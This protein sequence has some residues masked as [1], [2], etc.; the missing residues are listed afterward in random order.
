MRILRLAVAG[1]LLAPLAYLPATAQRLD[2][3]FAAPTSIYAPAAVFAIGQ[4][5][6]DGKRLVSGS[7]IRVNGI[8]TGR[9]VRLDATGAIDA[10]F[11]QNVGLGGNNVFRIK[12]LP[13]GQYLLGANGGS[14]TVGATSRVELLRLNAN[15]TPDNSF[16]P[17]PGPDFTNDYGF[18]QEYAV[19]ADGKV[20][21]TGHFDS[22]SGVAAGSVVRLNVD[23]SVDTGFTAGLGIVSTP[24][25][26]AVGNSVAVQA[27][28]KILVGGDFGTFNGT[29][30]PGIVR[31]NANGTLDT[32]FQPALLA[33][34]QVEGVT[35]QPDGKVLVNGYLELPG[36]S[37]TSMVRLLPS[38]ALDNSFTISTGIFPSGSISTGGFDTAVQL[39]TD[40]KIVVA[41]YFNASQANG[42]ARLNANGSLDTSFQFNTGANATPTALGLEAN[43]S[44]LI[45]SFFS[46]FN[47]QET[48]LLRLTSAGTPDPT[49]AAKLQIPGNVAAMVRQADGKL[50]C[51]DN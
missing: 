48:N 40:G 17:G 1:L 20:V 11:G 45:G 7:F 31:L 30:T 39:Q 38:G 23:G 10:A 50:G 24:T 34:S 29:A 19:Q 47:N 5:Q 42:V 26:Y 35:L 43:G 51:T 2:P 18:V 46:P 6:A 32:S 21:V 44:V 14:I 15:G 37:V 12:N 33:N 8:A 16:V 4:Q 22:Y 27:D 28:G 41:G 13:N 3:T 49:F 36:S 9:L 25:Q